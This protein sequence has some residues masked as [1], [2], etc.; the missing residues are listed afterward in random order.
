MRSSSKTVI[1]VRSSLARVC[2][3]V[4]RGTRMRPVQQL[5]HARTRVHDLY[6]LMPLEGFPD[7]RL[8]TWPDAKVKVLAAPALGA[9][10]VQYLIELPP[11]TRGTFPS[12]TRLE[13]FYFVLS[14]TGRFTDGAGVDH[15]IHTGSFGLTPPARATEIEATEPSLKLLIL[16][17]R[18]EP[19]PGAADRFEGVYGNESDVR[20][21]VWADNPHSLL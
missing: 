10:F 21:E 18:Y 11:G 7:S 14:G 19:A 3:P 20:K 5:V 17:K 1:F 2:K 6:A 15:T 8:P 16:R 9:Q 4:S 12:D 13:T